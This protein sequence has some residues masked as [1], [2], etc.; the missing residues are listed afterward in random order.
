MKDAAFDPL[1]ASSEPPPPFHGASPQQHASPNVHANRSQ[2][3]QKI[4]ILETAVDFVLALEAPC[5]AHLPY[6]PDLS[7]KDPDN[8]VMLMST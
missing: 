5:M 7:G 3:S 8:H 2:Q 4:D 6:P 1:S